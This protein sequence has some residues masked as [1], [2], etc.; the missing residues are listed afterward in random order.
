MRTKTSFRYARRTP[1][2]KWSHETTSCALAFGPGTAQY[3]NY[4]T[5]IV[6]GTANISKVKNFT[7]SLTSNN[8]DDSTGKFVG[9]GCGYVLVYVPNSQAVSVPDWNGPAAVY[10]P[11][12]FLISAGVLSTENSPIRIKSSMSRILNEGDSIHLIIT[13]FDV[14]AMESVGIRLHGLVEYSIT[15]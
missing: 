9:T 8:M 13:T 1:F 11:S 15:Q 10:E 2:T 5:T 12:N 6:T 3:Y 14:V 4:D 7:I